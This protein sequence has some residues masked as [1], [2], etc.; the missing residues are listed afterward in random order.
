[1]TDSQKEMSNEALQALTSVK[2]G[3]LRKKVNA[4]SWSDNME[5]LMKMWGEKAAGLRFMHDN[6]AGSWKKFSNDLTLWSIC[7][8]TVASGTSL[9]A[10][11]IEDEDIKNT[12]LYIVGGVGIVSSLL[13]SLKKF[14][15]AEE[16]SAD[17]NAVARQFGT[18]YRYMTLQLN[19][20]RE[21]RLPSDQLSDYALKEYERLQQEAPSLG[22]KQIEL[23]RKTFADSNQAI[24]D[25]CEKS[26]NI[27]I[28]KPIDT[29]SIK[30]DEVYIEKSTSKSTVDIEMATSPTNSSD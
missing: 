27:K 30:I 12:I 14:Y 11:S 28:Y 2:V 23:F 7:I 10:A 22:G 21:D 5:S 9:I 1:M 18:F 4:E 13:Q 8:T 26:F 24:P 19:L 15:N 17:H 6:A 3:E 16:K 20:T 25:V 29:T